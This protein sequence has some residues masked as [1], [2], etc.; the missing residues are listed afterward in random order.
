MKFLK[1]DKFKK[2]I[3][4]ICSFILVF[5]ILSVNVFALTTNDQN[6]DENTNTENHFSNGGGISFNV[7]KLYRNSLT[8]AL[9]TDGGELENTVPVYT[10]DNTVVKDVNGVTTI[11][12][13]NSALYAYDIRLN[14]ITAFSLSVPTTKLEPVFYVNRDFV[15]MEVRFNVSFTFRFLKEQ[16][17]E[18]LLWIRENPMTPVFDLYYGV[19]KD[20]Y[21]SHYCKVLSSTCESFSKDSVTYSYILSTS[22]DKEGYIVGFWTKFYWKNWGIWMTDYDKIHIG[23]LTWTLS[24]IS[25]LYYDDEIGVFFDAENSMWTQA[26]DYLSRGKTKSLNAIFGNQN[27]RSATLWLSRNL[28]SFYNSNSWLKLIIDFSLALGLLTVIL[29]LASTA[30]TNFRKENR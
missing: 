23:Y 1:S 20:S 18:E 24:P 9:Y 7:W 12:N 22:F 16:K 26:D 29:G 4:G 6:F 3:F 25:F 17:P 10:N 5:C 14:Y 28:E 11:S 27:L 19:D 13:P 15:G 8:F 30:A 2:F 21:S